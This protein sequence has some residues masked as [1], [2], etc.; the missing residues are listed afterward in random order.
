MHNMSDRKINIISLTTGKEL[1]LY[2]DTFKNA[3][4]WGESAEKPYNVRLGRSG[5]S[6]KV[7]IEKNADGTFDIHNTGGAQLKVHDRCLE[8]DGRYYPMPGRIQAHQ[9]MEANRRNGKT[10]LPMMKAFWSNQPK[11]LQP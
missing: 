5:S 1:P 8:V 6:Q 11:A 10:A 4:C 2:F 9:L 7:S 3:G